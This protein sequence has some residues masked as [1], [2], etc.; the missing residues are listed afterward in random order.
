ML[1]RILAHY[2]PTGLINRPKQGFVI[3]LDHWLRGPLR[4]WAEAMLDRGRLR[5][6]GVFQPEPIRQ[7]WQE[8]VSGQESRSDFLWCILMFQAWLEQWRSARSE[9]RSATTNLGMPYQKKPG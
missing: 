8:H 7:A 9:E 6:E 4:D 5:T 1:R 3:P 2:V